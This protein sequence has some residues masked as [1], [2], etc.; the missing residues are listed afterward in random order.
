MI[1]RSGTALGAGMRP[2]GWDAVP[3]GCVWRHWAGWLETWITAWSAKRLL[4]SR[5]GMQTDSQLRKQLA[6]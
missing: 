4:A 3:D 1:A 2:F 5:S 6:K